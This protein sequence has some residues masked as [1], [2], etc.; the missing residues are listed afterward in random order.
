[1]AK[2]GYCRVS[3]VDQN[4]DRQLEALKRYQVEKVFTDKL[5]GKDTNR[6]GLK[7]MLDYVRSGDTVYVSEFSRM[8]RST[9]DL[10]N[11]I[12][13]LEKKGVKVI[14]EKE[15]LDTTTPSGKLM[16]TFMIGIA[17]FER[18]I[19]L[20]RQREGIAVAKAKGHYKGRGAKS[21]PAEWS[22][23]LAEYKRRRMTATE[24]AKRCNVSRTLLY[25][26]I[27]ESVDESKQR[28]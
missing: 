22:E 14:S 4:L 25:K 6:A 2:I 7:E 15:N 27:D 13:K 12:D 5:S 9:K 19:M 11:I 10:L 24:L 21:K 26:W 8:A 18:D 23:W 1:M 17:E 3:T 20:E 28:E 16:R